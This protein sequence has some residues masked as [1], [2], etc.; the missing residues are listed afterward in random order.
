MQIHCIAERGRQ[1]TDG[2]WLWSGRAELRW[3][4][5]SDGSTRYS[6]GCWMTSSEADTARYR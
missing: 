1:E 4:I 3:Q 6:E 2:R 5:S